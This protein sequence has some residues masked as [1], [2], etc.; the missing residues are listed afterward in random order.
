VHSALEWQVRG[1]NHARWEMA[2][3]RSGSSQVSSQAVACTLVTRKGF[4]C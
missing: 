1:M 4:D 3:E 2:E